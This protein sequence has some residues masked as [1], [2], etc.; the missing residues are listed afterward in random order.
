[1]LTHGNYFIIAHKP[2]TVSVLDY[3]GPWT[4]DLLPIIGMGVI[5][6]LVVY[7]PIGILK[8]EKGSWLLTNYNCYIY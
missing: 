1:M 5:M 6:F 7:S 2:Q 4:I 3:S 8:R